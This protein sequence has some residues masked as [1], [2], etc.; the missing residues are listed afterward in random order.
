MQFPYFLLHLS[1]PTGSFL[2]CFFLNKLSNGIFHRA[3]VAT[4]LRCSCTGRRLT[5]GLGCAKVTQ[6]RP[7][8]FCT[9]T[10]VAWF[11]LKGLNIDRLELQPLMG[12]SCYDFYTNWKCDDWVVLKN[13]DCHSSKS[14]KFD[15][16]KCSQHQRQKLQAT[17]FL[18]EHDF[19]LGQFCTVSLH[20]GKSKWSNCLKT[21]YRHHVAHIIRI[22]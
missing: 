9:L 21:Q 10:T 6:Q 1:W 22:F 18:L 5:K 20:V 13:M 8:T 19:I 3:R 4:G 15:V 17:T 11:R 14:I 2:G 12:F 16:F 7:R